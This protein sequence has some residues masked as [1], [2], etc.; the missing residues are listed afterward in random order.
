MRLIASAVVLV[1]PL[2]AARAGDLEVE[3]RLV[4]DRGRIAAHEDARSLGGGVL[5]AYVADP[6]PG[7]RAAA[8]RALGR[9]QDAGGREAIVR[10]LSDAD[11]GVRAEAAFALGQMPEGG[12][13]AL[14]VR[15]AVE[16][17]PQVRRQL[18]EAVGRAGGLDAVPYL[19]RMAEQGPP[20]ERGTAL[21]GLGLVAKRSP[22]GALPGIDAARLDAWLADPAREVR[23]GASYA[24]LRAKAL[25]DPAAL[26]SAKRC[27]TDADEEVRVHCVR[28]L[29]RFP[30]A[31][32]ALS[33]AAGD[34]A[35]RVAAEAAKGLG[36]VKAAEALAV[37]LRAVPAQKAALEGPA[38]HPVVVALDA[39]LAL[40]STPALVEAAQAIHAMPPP[41]ETLAAK[42]AG[43]GAS[44][45]H[46]RAAALVDR[47]TGEPKLVQKCGAPDHPDGLRTALATK[48]LETLPPPARA[49]ALAALFDGA[50]PAGRLAILGALSTLGEEREARTVVLRALGEKDPAVVGEAAGA[51]AAM[52]LVEADRPLLEAYGRLMPQ[53]EYEAVQA[54]FEALGR[55]GIQAASAMLRQNTTHANPAIRK[56]A[57]EALKGIAGPTPVA[58]GEAAPTGPT[59]L[60]KPLAPDLN[61]ARPPRHEAATLHTTKGSI[62]VR[63][64]GADAPGT[65]KN[66]E[67]LAG[68][69]YYDGLTF[70]RV[71]PDFVVQGGDP[72]GDGWGGPGHTIRCEVN[73]RPYVRGTLGMALAGKDTGGSQFFIT[74]GPQ[75]HLDGGYTVFGQVVDGL[76]VVDALTVGDRIL[77]IELSR[78]P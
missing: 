52:R 39:A 63:L 65:V 2:A 37:R 27:A 25:T 33:A 8:V 55:L 60:P 7:I 14:V 4:E 36:E 78:A 45:V 64:F 32:E 15:H 35:W 42:P 24:L 77:K 22:D 56:A 72:R 26:E 3:R 71:V 9:L 70:H 62:R 40:P 44:H 19:A 12:V 30:A 54:I 68:S 50:T 10:A 49:R 58:P 38:L 67:N 74:H 18:V 6:R 28:A 43:I 53:Q 59:P 34:P 11:A 20:V 75:P 1:V 51:A 47:A 73:P 66:F 5:A 31:V 29:A 23:F 57:Q 61:L 17:D 41:A 16:A 21:V 46:C 76:D 48:V 69:G 13:E